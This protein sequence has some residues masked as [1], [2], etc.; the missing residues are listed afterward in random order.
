MKILFITHTRIGDAV[1]STGL[2]RHLVEIYPAARFTIVC[3]PL[4]APLFAAVPNCDRVI[5][6]TKRPYDAHWFTLWTD[7]RRTRWDIA[8]DLRRSLIT[9]LIP[10]RQRFVLGPI[11]AGQHH[12]RHLSAL[13]KI[14]PPPSPHIYVSPQHRARAEALVPD[15][16]PVLALAPLAADPAKTWPL[17]SFEALAVMLMSG[18]LCAGWRIALI[19][20]PNDAASAADLAMAVP[21]CI[22]I[23]NE[24]DLLTVA[25]VLARARAFI[26]NDSGL[27][28]MAA[29]VGIPTLAIFGPTDPSRYGP[30]GGQVVIAPKG[31]LSALSVAAVG[32]AF[33][34]L[35]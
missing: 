19:G 35:V 12:V 20:G 13:L 10:C 29:A 6:M 1:M 34:R 3:G 30:W 22:T 28:H 5:V 14:E 16:P 2:L 4:A 27:G 26:G 8:V 33:K 32:E 31:D 15:G 9:Y 11:A 18:G 7:V 21:G 24:P 23:F 17:A 25:A